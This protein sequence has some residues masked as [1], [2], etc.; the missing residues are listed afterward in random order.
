MAGARYEPVGKARAR[1]ITQA[2]SGV[3]PFGG[4]PLC[5]GGLQ[6]R[7]DAQLLDDT[8]NLSQGSRLVE[9]SH[10]QRPSLVKVSVVG[11]RGEDKHTD[12]GMG[13]TDRRN[14]VEATSI[15]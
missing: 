6:A 3:H 7:D 2:G 14:Q 4:S 13:C 9:K 8:A 1:L 12:V 10:P 11:G 15:S 5:R